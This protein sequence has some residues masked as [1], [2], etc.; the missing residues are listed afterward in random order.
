MKIKTNFTAFFLSI[1]VMMLGMSCSKQ[2]QAEKAALKFFESYTD[3]SPYDLIQD[4][5]KTEITLGDLKEIFTDSIAE[6]LFYVLNNYSDEDKMNQIEYISDKYNYFINIG[7]SV[8]RHDTLLYSFKVPFPERKEYVP[9]GKLP[10]DS[11][12]NWNVFVGI[13]NEGCYYDNCNFL[14]P[15]INEVVVSWSYEKNFDF[16]YVNDKFILSDRLFYFARSNS[17]VIKDIDKDKNQTKNDK[18]EYPNFDEYF[19]ENIEEKRIEMVRSKVRFESAGKID[20]STFYEWNS[21]DTADYCGNG[22]YEYYDLGTS[23]LTHYFAYRM[24]KGLN[25]QP[26]YTKDDEIN[27]SEIERYVGL[28]VILSKDIQTGLNQ[29]NPAFINWITQNLIPD[30]NS[31]GQL[32]NKFVIKSQLYQDAYS[33]Y[34]QKLV[35]EYAQVYKE[36]QVDNMIE[37]EKE[38]YLNEMHKKDFEGPEYLMKKYSGCSAFIYGFWLRRS[39]DGTIDACWN[40]CKNVMTLYDKEYYNQEFKG[41]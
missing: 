11:N 21:S 41:L 39:M 22:Y 25:Q 4:A 5:Y 36:L 15:K 26:S 2:K 13:L 3:K 23:T 40:A 27:W 33:F 17:Y 34:F 14:K 10:E 1:I 7:D 29:Y 6:V 35:R 24:W 38:L 12:Y 19:L 9:D 16:I 8:S 30:P 32:L 18:K 20:L 37:K 31:K 28:K